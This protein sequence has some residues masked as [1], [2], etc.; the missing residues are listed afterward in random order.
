[1]YVFSLNGGAQPPGV[2]M[3]DASYEITEGLVQT[4]LKRMYLVWFALTI[5]FFV[6]LPGPV[7]HVADCGYF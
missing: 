3:T 4:N 6:L 2:N 1:M 7:I 5:A